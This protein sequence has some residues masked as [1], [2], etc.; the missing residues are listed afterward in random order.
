MAEWKIG[1]KYRAICAEINYKK[2]YF[3]VLNFTPDGE[4]E[5]ELDGEVRM[6]NVN[7]LCL[8]D[9]FINIKEID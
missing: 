2:V 4:L 8:P 1:Q 9:G 3:K 7:E 6:I 5:V